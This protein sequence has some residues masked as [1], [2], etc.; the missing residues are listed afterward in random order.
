MKFHFKI[1]Q[2]NDTLTLYVFHQFLQRRIISIYLEFEHFYD[3]NESEHFFIILQ[4]EIVKKTK[5][6]LFNIILFIGKFL[7]QR[8][9][10]VF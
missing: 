6:N 2:R 4:Y 8:I 3:W 5:F 10:I 9:G 7:I 1:L